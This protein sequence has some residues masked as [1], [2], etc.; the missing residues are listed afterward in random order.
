V[1]VNKYV[2]PKSTATQEQVMEEFNRRRPPN[3]PGISLQSIIDYAL[4][5]N[6]AFSWADPMYVSNNFDTI[7]NVVIES[8]KQD[9]PPIISIFGGFQQ[10]GVNQFVLNFHMV[11]VVGWNELSFRIHDTETPAGGENPRDVTIESVR[12]G[13]LTAPSQLGP[14]YNPSVC[15]G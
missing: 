14:R 3:G 12:Q 1:S 13:L 7:R 9:L 5:D 4:R 6:P 8:V 11:T 10:I 15:R 2:N